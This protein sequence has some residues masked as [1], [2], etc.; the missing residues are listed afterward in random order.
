MELLIIFLKYLEGIE[1]KKRKKKEKIFII[2]P[3]SLFYYIFPSLF[4]LT[5]SLFYFFFLSLSP[6]VSLF[7][8]SFS[9]LSFFILFPSSSLLLFFLLSPSAPSLCPL[10]L[11][12][13]SS[14][15]HRSFFF[16]SMGSL[17]WLPRAKT[18]PYH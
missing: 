5:P 16:F 11:S 6:P 9:P 14:C 18:S 3:L 2:F 7:L 15:H 12:S 8:C 1:M 10:S 17:P 13:C 4:L